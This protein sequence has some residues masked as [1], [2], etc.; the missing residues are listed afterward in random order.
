MSVV[1]GL[2]GHCNVL[3]DTLLVVLFAPCKVSKALR[4]FKALMEVIVY[5]C[6]FCYILDA[7]FGVADTDNVA[8]DKNMSVGVDFIRID[9]CP[10]ER[11]MP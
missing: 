2:I 5:L 3:Y 9:E 10:V 8:F 7:Y 1:I 11:W 6:G 4:V